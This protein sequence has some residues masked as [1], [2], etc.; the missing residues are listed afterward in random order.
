MR[1]S[2]IQLLEDFSLTEIQDRD[3]RLLSGG[4]QRRASLAIGA[5]MNP[6]I[7]LLD[8]PTANLDI[9]T[10]KQMIFMLS[11][12]RKH[13]KTVIIATHDMQLVSEWSNRVIVMNQGKIIRDADRSGVFEDEALLMQAGLESP[14]ILQLSR[15]LNMH[16][17]CYTVDEFTK[18]WLRD[19]RRE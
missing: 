11:Q 7:I 12:L 4:Q 8:E 16:P 15:E 14:Q 5:A 18:Y 1:K 17:P 19:E 9:A 3:G 10:K 13:V 6:E 2:L